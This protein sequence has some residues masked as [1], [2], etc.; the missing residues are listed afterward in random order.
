MKIVSRELTDIFQDLVT[1]L[2]PNVELKPVE[3]TIATNE[4]F[5]DY[6]C[7]FAMINSKI[8]G[9]N[10]RN[11]AENI[12]NNFPYGA[13]VEK[14]EVAGPGFINIFL[15]NKFLSETINKI[16]EKYDFSFLNA[17]GD[18]V[19]DF[20]SP[21]IAKRM[22]IGHL[23]STIIGESISRIYKYLG[24]NVVA[25]N[26]IGD[27]GTQFGKLI[28][29]YRKWLN[30]EAYKTNPIEEL[31]RVYVKFSD[32]ADENPAL[33]DEA[34]AEL[35]KL[36]DGEEE[37]TK[38]WK[39]FI[40]ASLQE[41]NKLYKRLDIH[42]DTYYGESFYND[43]MGDVLKELV[44]KNIAKD[45][46][47]AKVVFFNEED[48]LYPCI[49]QKKDG[50]YLYS[51]SDIATIKFRKNTYDV[52]KLVYL[53]DSRQQ[54]HFKQVFKITDMLDW[55]IEKHHI[56]F[57]IIRFADAIL[58]T[59]KGNIIKL[60]ELLDEAHTRAYNIV[61]EKNS[62]LS[63]EEKQNIA[64]IVGTSSV[65]YAD[66]SQNKQS[67]IMF[68]WDKILSFEG[69]TAPYLLYTY[70][71]IQSILRK[72]EEQGFD[73]KDIELNLTNNF[74]RNLANHLLNLPISVLK[75]AE[76]FKPNLIADY[77]YELSK[78]LN[79]FYN[80][81]PILNQ[82]ENILKT[83]ALLI[84]KTGEVLKEGLALLGISVLNKM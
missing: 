25:D 83:R 64:E 13:V 10:P 21:N 19:I 70:A 7:N 33:E 46:Q 36:Q 81:C 11:I 12:K 63:E 62:S 43:M 29:G 68:E 28:V 59:R 9:D 47:G 84:K 39:E 38:L 30:Q 18:V 73:L 79:T 31:E 58:S 26:H 34:R 72:V 5:G 78:K 74:E 27:W 17:K 8:I 52:N 24:Y 35:K 1:K 51:T 40:E 69:N 44:D 50:A 6:Q 53:T 75:S 22:H 80:N 32:E 37:N 14:L 56:W 67:D 54:D 4:K 77:L 71:R 45:D 55:N 2:Y 20:S 60:E 65:K 15:S 16:G 61:N 48:N 57:G 76:T 42:F 23:R 82:E 41:Y 49:V 3:I 66:L